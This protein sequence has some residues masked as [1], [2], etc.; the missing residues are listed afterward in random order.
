MVPLLSRLATIVFSFFMRRCL[1]CRD[2][3]NALAA[4]GVNHGQQ[5]AVYHS[6]DDVSDLAWLT[7]KIETVKGEHIVECAPRHLKADTMLCE[8][9]LGFGIVP[10]EMPFFHTIRSARSFVKSS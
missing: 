8:V 2:D 6:G 10:F 3:P 1:S 9:A 5:D 4:L 7:V